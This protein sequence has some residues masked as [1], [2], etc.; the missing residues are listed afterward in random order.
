M[1]AAP[2]VTLREI[3]ADTL[4]SIIRLDVGEHQK[5]FVAPNSVSIAQAHFEPKA[6]FR[7]I[8][9]GEEPI[10]FVMVYENP[11]ESEYFLWRFMIDHRHQGK[12]YG[13]AAL[14]QVIERIRGLPAAT[15]LLTSYLPGEGSPGGFYH[16]MGFVDNGDE[17]EGESITVLEF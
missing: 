13:R 9:A 10:G 5:A 12:G 16:R 3:T 1:P 2:P 8:Y 15:R 11:E 14:S 6:W 4:R 7:A 17:D